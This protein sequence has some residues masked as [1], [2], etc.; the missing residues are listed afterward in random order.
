MTVLKKTLL[1]ILAF[2]I[3]VGAAYYQKITGP[4]YP[5]K[6]HI[7]INGI[8]TVQELKRTQ[9]NTRPCNIE[10]QAPDN[11]TGQLFFRRFPGNEEWSVTAMQRNGNILSATL[12]SQ[13]AAGK[14]EYYISLTEGQGG[15]FTVCKENPVIIRFKG[16]VPAGVLIPHVLLMFAAMLLST[17]AG[18]FAGFGYGSQKF[19]G[20][21]TLLMLLAGGFILGPLVQKYA[22]GELWTGIPFGWDLTDNKTL[23]ATAVWLAAVL[24][25]RK[26][27][28]RRW[29]IIAAIVLLVVYS[30]PHS[31]FGSQLD[32]ATNSVTQGF[33]VK[34][35]SF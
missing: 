13:P 3:T 18:L 4:T 20:K 22:F 31:L 2:A 23:I 9:N 34:L 24:L 1:W 16:D 26:K 14:L 8:T 6:A 30:I 12:P 19:Y 10:I 15:E 32:Y 17:L 21:L 27:E 7:T 33:M 28:S 11:I 35:I 25:N 29:T 5:A